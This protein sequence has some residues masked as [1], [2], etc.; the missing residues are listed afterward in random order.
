LRRL[1]TR[2]DH[3]DTFKGARPSIVVCIPY[4]EQMAGIMLD[5]KWQLETDP[6]KADFVIETERARCAAEKP[7][8]VKIDEVTRYDRAFAWTFVNPTSR[9]AGATA[10]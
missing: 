10:P 7:A 4:R 3:A 6:D 2:L 5:A 9:Y 8:L 1:E